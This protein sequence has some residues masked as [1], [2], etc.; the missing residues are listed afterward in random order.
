[1]YGPQPIPPRQIAAKFQ[2]PPVLDFHHGEAK[3][4]WP[5]ATAAFGG[6]GP[7][8]KEMV[9]YFAKKAYLGNK[10]PSEPD[11]YRALSSEIIRLQMQHCMMTFSDYQS[12]L[13]SGP[14]I[15]VPR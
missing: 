12:S 1:M 4:F 8:C 14:P 13:K 2:N 15:S 3:C 10:F 11:A 7:G 6:L 9:S 5:I